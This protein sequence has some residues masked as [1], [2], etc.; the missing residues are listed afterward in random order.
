[1]GLPIAA[2][3]RNSC[4]ALIADVVVVATFGSGL[5]QDHSY[6]NGL[7]T[8]TCLPDLKVVLASSLRGPTVSDPLR[9]APDM[10]A[11]GQNIT[12]ALHDNE[13]GTTGI[14]NTG[15]SSSITGAA[16][17]VKAARPATDGREMKAVLL[18]HTENRVYYTPNDYGMGYLRDDF[19][20]DNVRVPGRVVS[21]TIAS[22]STPRYT[23]SRSPR[24]AP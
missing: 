14:N 3:G 23:T 21:G 10:I 9:T 2:C 19:A 1:M 24:A 20:V 15:A 8:G 17:L 7:T 22:T 18:A 11:D 4:S 5:R 6:I 13:S 16:L 12:T